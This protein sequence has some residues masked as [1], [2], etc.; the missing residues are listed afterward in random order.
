MNSFVIILGI[1]SIVTIL[2]IIVFYRSTKIYYDIN[3]T[4]GY[5]RNICAKH[6]IKTNCKCNKNEY[7]DL[8]K[9]VL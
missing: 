6:K 5:V 7:E 3:Q 4:E 1:I 8:P 2:S 9:G